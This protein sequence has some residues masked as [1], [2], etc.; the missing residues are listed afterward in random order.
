MT[1]ETINAK[2]A[3][4]Y[5]IYNRT[6]IDMKAKNDLLSSIKFNESQ[7][8]KK[9]RG[10]FSLILSFTN[11]GDDRHERGHG[12]NRIV[13]ELVDEETFRL[14]LDGVFEAVAQCPFHMQHF[15]SQV[16]KC[17]RAFIEKELFP[18][19]LKIFIERFDKANQD[20]LTTFQPLEKLERFD[21]DD[22]SGPDTSS[23]EEQGER[24]G[25]ETMQKL[26]RISLLCKTITQLHTSSATMMD[27]CMNPSVVN[28][29]RTLF[30][31]QRTLSKMRVTVLNNRLASED[32]ED[33]KIYQIT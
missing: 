31:V 23:L 7:T 20:L 6:D 21:F 19:N 9:L 4:Y 24:R 11:A 17:I 14:M 1:H 13:Q 2:S 22:H 26:L 25:P 8:V 28:A 3:K 30:Y 29:V 18:G 15:N 16:T 12:N 5:A 33:R 32:P 10:L 27:V